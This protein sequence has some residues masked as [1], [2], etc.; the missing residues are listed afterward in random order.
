MGTKP[1][2]TKEKEVEGMDPSG[3]RELHRRPTSTKKL[4]SG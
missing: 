4:V 3:I 2:R 1:Y